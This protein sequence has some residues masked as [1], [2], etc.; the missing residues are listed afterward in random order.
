MHKTSLVYHVYNM[1]LNMKKTT[2]DCR[3]SGNVRSPHFNARY[4]VQATRLSLDDQHCTTISNSYRI[5]G[6]HSHES[7][8]NG[9]PLLITG[10]LIQNEPPTFNTN[11]SAGCI[12]GVHSIIKSPPFLLNANASMM[13]MYLLLYRLRF[14]SLIIFL[15]LTKRHK[16]G[17]TQSL[18][19]LSQP[20]RHLIHVHVYR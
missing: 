5:V 19:F 14:R 18:F 3:L 13:Y 16:C 1:H 9:V 2:G 4:G 15:L 8:G 12:K 6:A 20:R 11:I 17:L 10:P 7:P